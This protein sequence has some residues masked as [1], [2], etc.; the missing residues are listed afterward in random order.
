MCNAIIR[1][2]EGEEIM[3][4]P[5]S[6]IY[7]TEEEYLAIERESEE[8]HEYIDGRIYAMAGESEEHGEISSNIFGH[9][10][11]RLSGKPCRARHEN[12][13]VRSGPEPKPLQRSRGFYSYPDVLVVCGERRFHDKFR[14][15]L[16]NPNVIIEVLS[17]S[18]EPFDRGEKFIR[19]RT[20]LPALT[21]Y[22]LVAQDKPMIEHYRRQP[23]GEW[24]LATVSGLDASLTIA[25]IGCELKLS[26]VYDAV[27]FPATTIE[28]D[29]EQSD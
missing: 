25:S 4:T 7:F 8:R 20:W 12:T 1:Q 17:E 22:I 21:D 15:V 28:L 2:V 3:A 27:N 9:L 23:N 10:F 5:Q 13:K 16:I 6:R 29:A 19:Y 11:A 24:T 18:T 14:D 26:E